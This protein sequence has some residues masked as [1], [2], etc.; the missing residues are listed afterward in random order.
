MRARLG[1]EYDLVIGGRRVKTEKKIV[2]MN[3]ARPAEV[4]GVHQAAGEE[5]VEA[6]MRAA[7][8][9]FADVVARRRWRSGRRCCFARR[10]WCA[11]ASSSCA[12]G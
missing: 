7:Q 10:G 9:A 6:A 2:S 1:R 11:S 12:R 3:P 5:H 8:A 4:V